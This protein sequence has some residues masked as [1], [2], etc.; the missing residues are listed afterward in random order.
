M[1]NPIKMDDLGVS[2][3]SETP[4]WVNDPKYSIQI[5]MKGTCVFDLRELHGF[6]FFQCCF[7]GPKP[8]MFNAPLRETSLKIIIDL[9]CLTPQNG[10]I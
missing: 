8:S 5:L 10:V 1:E 7:A 6:C 3:F 2:L 4:K 9:H